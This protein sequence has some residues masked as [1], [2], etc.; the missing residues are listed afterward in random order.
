MTGPNTETLLDQNQVLKRSFNETED[1]LRTETVIKNSSVPVIWDSYLVTYNTNDNISKIQYFS[2]S[3]LV[4]TR[5]Y[6]YDTSCK[7]IGSDVT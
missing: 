4:F 7:L 5:N 6:Y 3:S 1:R 2:A